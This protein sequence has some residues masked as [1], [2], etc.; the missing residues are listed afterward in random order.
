MKGVIILNLG[1][2][3]EPTARGLRNFYKYFFS[4]PFVFDMSPLSRWLLRNLIIMPFR[5]P[6]TANDYKKIWL[7]NGSPL[8][9]Y[10]EELRDSLQESLDPG[11]SRILVDIGMGYSEPFITD[12]MANFNRRGIKDVLIFPL[13]PQYSTATTGS[14][15]HAVSEAAAN[16]DEPPRRKLQL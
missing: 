1:T 8:K 3:F 12:T 7:D 11:K 5:A 14:V 13:F 4:D 16:W 2:P 9:V 15:L 6:K 10:T